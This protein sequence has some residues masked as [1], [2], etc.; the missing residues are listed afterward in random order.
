MA[1]YEVEVQI[2]PWENGGYRAEAVGLGGC[3]AVADTV[4]QAIE[5]IREVVHLWLEASREHNMPMP[6]KVA[7]AREVRIKVVVPVAAE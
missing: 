5:D 4:G 2:S 7:R 1:S 3:W 6:P